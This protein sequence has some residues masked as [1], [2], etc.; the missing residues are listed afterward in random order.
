MV[1]GFVHEEEQNK[2]NTVVVVATADSRL[3]AMSSVAG[4][5]TGGYYHELF[6]RGRPF[7][8]KYIYRFKG[9]RR[10]LPKPPKNL[11]NL[12]A[13]PPLPHSD[14]SGARSKIPAAFGAVAGDITARRQEA[15]SPIKRRSDDADDPG[16]SSRIRTQAGTGHID[17]DIQIRAGKES[18]V[19][20]PSTS[21]PPYSLYESLLERPGNTGESPLFALLRNHD[22]QVARGNLTT[23]TDVR[24]TP[25]LDM[26]LLGRA[27]SSS[28]TFQ[29]EALHASHDG[30]RYGSPSEIAGSIGSPAHPRDPPPLRIYREIPYFDQRCVL[31]GGE[32]GARSTDPNV[33]SDGQVESP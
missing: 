31:A 18:A 1:F 22:S 28:A 17:G 29:G 13:W 9:R 27:S 3:F 23:G 14:A 11:P 33:D 6:L 25:I 8:A 5:D 12:Y 7:L 26:Q 24:P 30:D 15:E 21:K 2:R 10:G 16:R 32:G 20:T 19:P 4:P